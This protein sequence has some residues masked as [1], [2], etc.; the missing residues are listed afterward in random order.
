MDN[1]VFLDLET[2]G[3]DPNL[4]EIIEFGLVSVDANLQISDKISFLARPTVA[5]PEHVADLTGIDNQM[6]EHSQ[7]LL[8]ISSKINELL[9]QKI[10]VGHNIQFDI[11]FLN[12]QGLALE[13]PY[14]DTFELSKVLLP[15]LYR[16]SLKAL[17]KIFGIEEKNSHRAL[18]D[19]ILTYKVFVELLNIAV[20]VPANELCLIADLAVGSGWNA[21]IFWDMVI[22]TKKLEHYQRNHQEFIL[23]ILKLGSQQLDTPSMLKKSSADTE[24]NDLFPFKGVQFAEVE[25]TRE[26][27]FNICQTAINSAENT[28]EK[29]IFSFSN[30]H[31]MRTIRDRIL[32][33]LRV[34]EPTIMEYHKEASFVCPKRLETFLLMPPYNKPF[35][36]FLS[37]IIVWLTTS[38]TLFF[39]DIRTFDPDN[40]F[41]S[42]ISWN[43][44]ICNQ[45]C[46][47]F[48]NCPVVRYQE[49]AR[50]SKILFTTHTE[51]LSFP[52]FNKD[53]EKYW[54]IIGD[55]W[56]LI[57]NWLDSLRTQ[58]TYEG[59]KTR[60]QKLQLFIR[61]VVE[62]PVDKQTDGETLSTIKSVENELVSFVDDI[63]GLFHHLGLFLLV[64]RKKIN[65]E[66]D[67]QRFQILESFTKDESFVEVYT[68]WEHLQNETALLFSNLEILIKAS[69]FAE[70]KEELEYVREEILSYKQLFDELFTSDSYEQFFWASV[71]TDG[72]DIK[73]TTLPKSVLPNL[74]E[75]YAMSDTILFLSPTV[76]YDKSEH[77]LLN[78]LKVPA[79]KEIRIRSFS[80]TDWGKSVMFYWTPGFQHYDNINRMKTILATNLQTLC[81]RMDRSVLVL[82]GSTTLM[83][84][85]HNK[86]VRQT[87]QMNINLLIASAENKN[88]IESE[89]ENGNQLLVFGTFNEIRKLDLPA[90]SFPVVILT[91][92]PFV[93]VT[94]TSA[95]YFSAN[96]KNLFEEFSLPE[97]VGLF[98]YSFNLL[99]HDSRMKSACLIMDPRIQSAEYGKFFLR[100][101]PL[102]KIDSGNLLHFVKSS[103]E[104]FASQ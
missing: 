51:L 90:N 69:Q 83:Y 8:Q 14:I 81:Q 93:D 48:S 62:F 1:L 91:K 85:V 101:L 96:C 12:K 68:K 19:A 63:Q 11:S 5:V 71:K 40:A 28:N 56:N 94:N 84:A 2:T 23:K 4:D 47:Y 74:S 43:D 57:E 27:Q 60:I 42:E 82:F 26:N 22:A 21:N 44:N 50:K 92:L 58:Y 37:R 13:N 33:E 75:M 102:C 38:G 88:E 34:N 52:Q 29:I 99:L 95:T 78:K 39:G 70:V 79:S 72:E 59:L 66:Y 18:D 49:T 103:S 98:R 25:N 77:Y 9:K 30:T 35:A 53:R 80:N 87:D 61:K 17:G 97:A 36:Q 45:S 41:R 3:L 64:S 46:N 20:N 67:N 104:W 16:Y 55:A 32:S 65:Y 73:I 76:F 86:I 15:D 10:L 89:I 7:G 31:T 6:L 54:L 100:D 24:F